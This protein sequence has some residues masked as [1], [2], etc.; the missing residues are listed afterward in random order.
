MYDAR[1]PGDEDDWAVADPPPRPPVERQRVDD[2]EK[3]AK[4]TWA[5]ILA[6]LG[7][8]ARQMEAATWREMERSLGLRL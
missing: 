1:D 8:T 5:T 3:A 2:A 6:G 4:D 7:E